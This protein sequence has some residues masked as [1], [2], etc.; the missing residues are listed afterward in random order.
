MPGFDHHLRIRL[1]AT[2][3]AETPYAVTLDDA[4]PRPPVVPLT[5]AAQTFVVQEAGSAV[6]L[7]QAAREGRLTAT[8]LGQLGRILG[9]LLL[10]EPI[11]ERL[12]LRL[13]TS[14]G[15]LRLLV[16]ID[17]PELAVLPWESLLVTLDPAAP[18]DLNDFL[19]LS[20][21]P[22]F[23]RSTTGTLSGPLP[24]QA[25]FRL[26]AAAGALQQRAIAGGCA[27][28]TQVTFKPAWLADAAAASLAAA[29]AEPA[30]VVHLPA[31][32]L[33][34]EAYIL[35]QRAALLARAGVRLAVLTPPTPDEPLPALSIHTAAQAL[36]RAGVAAVVAGTTPMTEHQ[37]GVFAYNLYAE[38]AAGA[39]LDDAV[40]QARRQLFDPERPEAWYGISLYL[41]TSVT[42]L[43]PSLAPATQI[44]NQ[45][46]QTVENSTIIG[47]DQSG[48]A[49]PTALR[50]VPQVEPTPLA[51]PLIG[52]EATLQALV[53]QAPHS[54]RWYL[55]GA[56]GVGKTS[57][58][59][60]LFAQLRTA[61]T[62]PDGVIWVS[63]AHLSPEALLEAVAAPFGDQRVAQA[64]GA[65]AKQN[66]LRELLAERP[67]TLIA[68]DDVSDRDA[69]TALFAT[70]GRRTMFLNGGDRIDLYD[71]A[72]V[73]E[74]EPLT[75]ADAA[76]LFQTAARLD[77]AH[78]SEHDHA[79]IAAICERSR[80]LP[81]AI[82]LAARY[83][84]TRLRASPTQRLGQLLRQLER[85]PETILAN[86][87]F[88]VAPIF[89]AGFA[90]LQRRSPAAVRMLVRL[91]SFPDY[92]A[93]EAEILAGLDADEAFS[94]P[95]ALYDQFL[96]TGTGNGRLA[97]HP[98]LGS[99]VQ[100]QAAEALVRQERAFV[101]AWLLTYAAAH[102]RDYAY[103][104]EEQNNLIGLLRRLGDEGRWA[105]AAPLLR[106]LFDFLRVRGL[107]SLALEQ[108][109]RL[110][111]A[112][113]QIADHTERGWIFL[114]RATIALL[115]A[116]YPA[117]E[118]DFAQAEAAFRA[119]G[120]DAGLGVVCERRAALLMHDGDL[121]GAMALLRTGIELMGERARDHDR[122][123]AHVRLAMILA[124]RGEQS[125][126][127]E[128]Y[129]QA[130]LFAEPEGQL[131]AKLALGR[132]AR[133]AGDDT[134]AQTHYAEAL[135][136]ATQLD[137]TLARA[138]VHQELGHLAYFQQRYPEAA[139]A[140]DAA[141]QGYEQLAYRPG[142][143]QIAH[144]RGNLA[145]AANKLDEAEQYYR[146]A[147]AM[148]AEL[149]IVPNLAYNHYMLG[150]VAQRRG[151]ADA[152]REHYAAAQQA[153]ERA[154]TYDVQL[155]AAALFQQAKLAVARN[156]LAEALSLLERAA[157][158][159]EQG[160]DKATQDLVA[161]LRRLISE[162]MAEAA[163]PDNA[164]ERPDL[165]KEG[166]FIPSGPPPLPE[167]D[168]ATF[169]SGAPATSSPEA[170]AA[171]PEAHAQGP[172]RFTFNR[173]PRPK[174]PAA[175]IGDVIKEGDWV[176][177]DR[178]KEGMSFG[179][180]A[181]STQTILS[182]AELQR[183]SPLIIDLQRMPNPLHTFRL[184]PIDIDDI[185]KED[186]LSADEDAGSD[187][188][189]E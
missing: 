70:A 125:A 25:A 1:T 11:R 183:D 102:E 59:T 96:V 187:V 103:L 80:Y 88:G 74:L 41:A 48:A 18:D 153:A 131:R 55:C 61:R 40:R 2:P 82:R 86:D 58:A 158:L 171:A 118:A 114:Q 30:A 189:L 72:E 94:A 152:A 19:A 111:E 134:A 159:A 144:A 43:F 77:P 20:K 123:A 161:Q 87:D 75:P 31:A 63:A 29:L 47:I 104:A 169:D 162:P 130:L 35:E 95:D 115:Q 100:Q 133:Q 10:P 51:A 174:D 155:L 175:P 105:E 53:D 167:D 164:G 79:L 148:N 56:F 157:E 17:P 137:Y 97:L 39:T 150:V 122:A 6:D 68:V 16:Q 42:T 13:R 36:L 14:D 71:L 149:E 85:R 109:D 178:V 181:G 50:V 176:L 154:E 165:I 67:N 4:T 22:S 108:L 9:D 5:I 119:A 7:A 3:L 90:R 12:R 140:F 98:L 146:T 93:Q 32:A 177:G 139:Q 128:H 138:N 135:R 99:L 179:H 66:A 44:V 120:D 24:P 156:A 163:P 23:V 113:D 76:R 62:F 160:R 110:A 182:A 15:L 185:V 37:A 136:L 81:L 147:E 54:G 52:R 64:S 112:V 92:E 84:G 21:N 142:L 145:L 91:A 166:G 170:A 65:T 173:I 73:V 106:R 28:A 151:Q 117:A 46:I 34:A 116:R 78:L 26:V 126:A 141:N 127:Q 184:K 186:L 57:F 49:M 60:A 132:L 121:A 69:A 172:G 188:D 38:L 89:A 27:A 101:E 129:C 8:E 33:V 168:W 107:W 180:V 45:T 143:A 83:A 124:I